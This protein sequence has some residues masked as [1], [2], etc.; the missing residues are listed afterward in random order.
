MQTAKFAG[1]VL[2]PDA[3]AE[4]HPQERRLFKTVVLGTQ[5]L[6]GAN[7][8]AY[9]LGVTPYKKPMTCSNTTA[10]LTPSF[11]SGRMR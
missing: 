5:Y 9:R 1:A 8:L 2:K 3:T 4:S 6:I 7:G 10:E 11:G